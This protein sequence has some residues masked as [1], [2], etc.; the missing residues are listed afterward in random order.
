VREGLNAV[1]SVKIPDP[2]FEGQTKSKLGNSEVEGIVNSFV[3]EKLAAYFEEFPSEAKRIISKAVGAAEARE[4]ARKARDLARRKNALDTGGLPGKLADCSEDDPAICE[5]Y[6]VEGDSAGG[7]AKMARDRRHQA[8]LPLKGKILNVEKARID[9]VL[10]NEEI[11][12]LITAIGAGVGADN[13]DIEKTRYHK[14]ILMTDADVD[15]AHIR[16][17]LLTFLFRQAK[18][19]IDAGY[20]YVAQPPLYKVKKGKNERYIL[21]ER[22]MNM[23]LTDAGLEGVKLSQKSK[24]TGKKTEMSAGFL[25]EVLSDILEIEHLI[26][27][28][29]R[30][31]TSIEAY[32]KERSGWDK[33]PAFEVTVKGKIEYA[34]NEKE[35]ADAA[36]KVLSKIT[37]KSTYEE[38]AEAQ[39]KQKKEL[40]I[41]DLR[42]IAEFRMA[43]D[44]MQKLERK[45]MDADELF[46]EELEALTTTDKEDKEKRKAAAAPMFKAMDTEKE[47]ETLIFSIREL[48]DYIRKRGKAGISIQRYKGLGEMNPD[49]LWETTMN[50][51]TRT[52]LQI[53]NEDAVKADEIFTI[54]MGDEV[55]PR[56]EFIE[57]HALEVKNLDI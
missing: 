54:L 45:G 41:I 56:R 22:E 19:L 42:E 11:R 47:E 8:I 23:Y 50:P 7:S 34:F 38:V 20:V 28:I 15:G 5:L 6:L 52:M 53:T 44:I 36:S 4:A 25:K 35:L 27:K 17:L 51:E 49:Q 30:S 29:R 39:A 26:P 3:Y 21:D 43:E 10:S 40:Q 37:K 32:L 31:G 2:Q 33:L 14:I 48:I 24:K 13:F 12:T 1:V 18:P 46:E 16:T 57:T 9:K 55:A